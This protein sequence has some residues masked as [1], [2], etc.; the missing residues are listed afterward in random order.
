MK[1]ALLKSLLSPAFFVRSPCGQRPYRQGAVRSRLPCAGFPPRVCGAFLG[2]PV[3]GLQH[4]D[5][6]RISALSCGV[7]TAP[8]ACG[9]RLPC[10]R[11]AGFSACLQAEKTE[12]LYPL[13]GESVCTAFSAALV[14]NPHSADC[15]R[16]SAPLAQ[17]AF[18]C[19]RWR[20]QRE[21]QAAAVRKCES[22]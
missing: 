21:R 6:G 2:S 4:A 17:L 1:R 7:R 8:T 9:S 12:G 18:E 14:Q 10:A 20:I 16:F 11:G 3:R 19:R 22:E 5:C 13:T 15:E